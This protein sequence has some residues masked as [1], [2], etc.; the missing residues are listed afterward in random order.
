MNILEGSSFS[1]SC[2]RNSFVLQMYIHAVL[3]DKNIF[4]VKISV[5]VDGQ[6]VYGVN[7]LCHVDWGTR[8][9][10]SP[11]SPWQT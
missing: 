6:C 8:D 3:S 2:F 7:V 10:S 5:G 9:P 1:S 4:E 11:S